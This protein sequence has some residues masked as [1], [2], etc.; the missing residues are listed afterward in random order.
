[1][2]RRAGG[3]RREGGGGLPGGVWAQGEGGSDSEGAVRAAVC[4]V[5]RVE[6][7]GKLADPAHHSSTCGPIGSC[8]YFS[9]GTCMPDGGSEAVEIGKARIRPRAAI[10]MR[11]SVH[12]TRPTRRWK[13][14]S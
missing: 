12:F 4:G 11:I 9:L 14:G 10:K 5:T 1:M 8:S 2:P 13:R 3:E 7:F 6:V